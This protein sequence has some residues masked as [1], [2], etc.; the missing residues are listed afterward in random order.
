MEGVQKVEENYMYPLGS[1]NSS[2][3]VFPGPGG[4]SDVHYLK[5]GIPTLAHW[6][7]PVG[8]CHFAT[9]TFYG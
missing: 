7:V 8:F 3:Q 4:V 5:H 1:L 9:S 6:P 2:F